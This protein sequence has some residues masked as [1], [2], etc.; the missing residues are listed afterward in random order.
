MRRTKSCFPAFFPSKPICFSFN[1]SNRNPLLSPTER[2]FRTFSPIGSTYISVPLSSSQLFPRE[3]PYSLAISLTSVASQSSNPFCSCCL[4][5]LLHLLIHHTRLVISCDG[6]SVLLRGCVEI[7]DDSLLQSSLLACLFLLNTPT[8]R[9]PMIL[10]D[11]QY[12]MEPFIADPIRSD[13]SFYY[14]AN[15]AVLTIMRSWNGLLIFGSDFDGFSNYVSILAARGEENTMLAKEML[16]SL[17]VLLGIP[18]PNLLM[19]DEIQRLS[20]FWTECSLYLDRLSFSSSAKQQTNLLTTYLSIITVI[21]LRAKL[22]ETLIPLTRHADKDVAYLANQLLRILTI[23]A[24]IFLPTSNSCRVAMITSFVSSLNVGRPLSLMG[25]TIASTYMY[26]IVQHKVYG[27]TYLVDFLSWFIVFENVLDY[28][29]ADSLSD[30]S[31]RFSAFFC[32]NQYISPD[33]MDNAIKSMYPDKDQ[34]VSLLSEMNVPNRTF[35]LN[36]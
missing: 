25:Y 8:Y 5:L 17:F 29:C 2:S 20:I 3:I 31:S 11:L 6:I 1:F 18:V 27:D 24:D 9:Q 21:C 12:V 30:E 23:L 33:M 16:S 34:F 14:I 36:V 22:P 32:S 4:H 13:S 35:L 15:L 26:P 7:Q 10:L 28:F 19:E